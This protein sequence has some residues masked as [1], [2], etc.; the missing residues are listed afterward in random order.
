[1]RIKD[2]D[3]IIIKK[4]TKEYFGSSARV[5]LF[6]SRINDQ[7]KGGDIDLYIETDLKKDIIRQKLKM[8]GML[9]EALGEQKIDIV[10]NN[11]V[12]DKYIYHI[13]KDEGI[14]L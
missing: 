4:I 6:G 2:E 10:V 7:K 14:R 9:H 13:A 11:F 12:N 5:Y 8:L 1:M 3:K